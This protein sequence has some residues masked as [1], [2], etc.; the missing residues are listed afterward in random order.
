MDD[1]QNFVQVHGREY[2]KKNKKIFFNGIGIGSWL[3]MEHFML[4]IPGTDAQIRKT[5]ADVLGMQQAEKFFDR[6]VYDFITEDDFRFLKEHRINLVRVPFNYRIFV[7]DQ[8]ADNLKEKGFQYLDYLMDLAHRYEIYVLLDLH[9]TPG[10]QNPDWHSDNGTGYTEFWEYDVFRRQ[11]ISLWGKIAAHYQ[12]E[13]YLLG[14]D[15]LNEPFLI[16]QLLEGN[17]DAAD[18]ATGI[19]VQNAAAILHDFYK[20]VIAAIR[21]NDPAHIIFLEG[22]HFASCFDCMQGITEEQLALEFHF[23]PTVWY[24]DL[25]DDNYDPAVRKAKF[26]E[27]MQKLT[28]SAE[29]FDRPILC[30]EAGYE[31]ATNG[32]EQTLPLI[33]DTLALFDQYDISF[34]LWSYKDA[35]FMGMVIPKADSLWMELQNRIALSWDHHTETERAEKTVTYLCDTGF[36]Q[37]TKADRYVLTFRQ[38]ALMYTL[39]EKYILKPLL[40]SCDIGQIMKLPESFLFSNCEQYERF[41]KLFDELGKKKDL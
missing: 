31:I 27:V 14:Y 24:P 10:G 8:D 28:A 18:I 3:N 26:A 32:F 16:P 40:Q 34:T 6:F 35:G 33:R 38:R 2:Y 19:A 9:T 36:Q 5:F 17:D 37:A 11:I 30:G 4:G 15:V 1:R 39:E 29:Q 22:D 20:K 13:E 23:Y 12:D 7:D 41:S 21:A 25:Y